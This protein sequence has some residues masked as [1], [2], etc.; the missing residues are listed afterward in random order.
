MIISSRDCN[1]RLQGFWFN[2]VKPAHPAPA[3]KNMKKL[4]AAS[5]LAFA[6][7]FTSFSA[8]TNQ[9]PQ[10][11]ADQL[12]NELEGVQKA[13]SKGQEQVFNVSYETVTN[14]LS[15]LKP[16]PAADGFSFPGRELAPGQFYLDVPEG[17]QGDVSGTDTS[18]LVTRIDAKSARVQMKT[19][20]LGLFFNSRD[21]KIEQQRLNELT[22]LLSNKN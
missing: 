16:N 19:I 12:R 4:L 14:K 21:R 17:P 11:S 5:F 8:P 18:I 1:G 15:A 3:K 22:Q 2:S 9:P 13:V 7:V 20:K 6:T 10:L